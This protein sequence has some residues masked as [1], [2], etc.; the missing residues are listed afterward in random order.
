MAVPYVN[1]NISIHGLGIK[2]SSAFDFLKK[3]IK[4]LTKNYLKGHRLFE[5]R[6]EFESDIQVDIEEYAGNFEEE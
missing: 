1:I 2:N 5:F 3:D 6:D 4:K